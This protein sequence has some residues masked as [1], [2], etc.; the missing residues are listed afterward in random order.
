MP[1]IPGKNYSLFSMFF[2]PKSFFIRDYRNFVPNPI[3]IPLNY[4]MSPALSDL[5]LAKHCKVGQ[6]LLLLTPDFELNRIPN[7]RLWQFLLAFAWF[8]YWKYGCVIV[9]S[10]SLGRVGLILAELIWIEFGWIKLS[11]VESSWVNLNQV[12]QLVSS[13][14]NL[15]Q[16]KSSCVKLCHFRSSCVK[17]WLDPIDSYYH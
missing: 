15:C 16:V 11:P 1:F 4:W 2:W 5:R 8:S 3:F 12:D 7:L 17:F 10:D 9:M 6:Q 13:C 14:A